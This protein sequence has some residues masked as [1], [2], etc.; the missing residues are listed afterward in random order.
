[1]G[2]RRW[3]HK[4]Q[5]KHVVGGCKARG[6]RTGGEKK[7]VDSGRKSQKEAGKAGI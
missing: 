1:V 6:D 3:A 2:G 7:K 5:R 4:E